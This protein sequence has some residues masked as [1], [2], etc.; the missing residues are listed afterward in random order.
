MRWP[1]PT[2]AHG[3]R[4]RWL[5]AGDDHVEHVRGAG[6]PCLLVVSKVDLVRP[7]SALLPFLQ[8]CTGRGDFVEIVPVSATARETLDRLSDLI[9]RYLPQ[10]PALYPLDAVTDRSREFR[11]A[12]V[13]REQLLLALRQEVPYGLAVQIEALE[14]KPGVMLVDALIWAE[15]DS[16]KG[17]VVGKG[18][19]TLK[20]IGTA[21]RLELE[22]LFDC[23]VHLET[24][25]RVKRNWA[26]SAR[27]LQQFGFESTS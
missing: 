20:A 21:A 24:H 23:K 8:S 25:V 10:G 3:R 9:V 4:G 18:G 15:R 14:E 27:M 22:R 26:D 12:E 11:V 1:A 2:R 19:E 16:H 13:L 5:E 17:I 7:K 6:I